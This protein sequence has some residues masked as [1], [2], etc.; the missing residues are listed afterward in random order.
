MGQTAPHY[1]TFGIVPKDVL[2][3]VL[4]AA[5]LLAVSQQNFLL[6]HTLAEFFAIVIAI[7]MLVV[8]WYM[9]PFTR[10]SFLLFLGCGYFWVG[11]LDLA[12]T[13]HYG[14][15]GVLSDAGGNS[16]TQY[17]ILTRYLES[18]ILLSAP[19]FLT[20]HFSHKLA[21]GLFGL[22]VAA[23]ITLQALGQLPDTYL[24]GSGLTP[25]KIYSEYAITAVL[26]LA[27]VNLR[28][29][30]HLLDSRMLNTMI[31]SIGLTIGAE[32]AFTFYVGIYD[33]SNIIG[34]LFKLASFWLIF[35][36][37][38]R[39]TL[40]EPFMA[41]SRSSS[42]YDAV[43][44]ATLVTD[45]EGVIRQANRSAA[46]MA[47]MSHVSLVGMDSHALFHPGYRDKEHCPVCQANREGRN[48][49]GLEIHDREQRR[50]YDVSLARIDSEASHQGMVQVIHDISQRKQA[51]ADFRTLSGLKDSIVENLPL[52]LFAKDAS[53]H[54]YV[55]WNKAAEQLTGLSK[56]E[57]LGH[58]DYDFWPKQEAEFFIRK[59]R[60][61]LDSGRLHDI[62]EETIS[63]RNG[64]RLLHTQ[65]IP[66]YS[67]DGTPSYLLGISQDI[68][69]QKEIE[70]ALQQSQ[71]LDA[72]G[73]LSGGIAH[74]YNNMLGIIQG[75]SE[76]LALH[77][78]GDEKLSQY[79]QAI[80]H[81][82]DRGASLSRQLLA[83]S[84]TN[85]NEESAVDLNTFITDERHI[86]E[87]TLTASI[88]LALEMQPHLW[89]V[90][91]NGGDLEDSLI[92]LV[93]N[94]MHAIDGSGTITI[95]TSNTILD[96]TDSNR[97]NLPA[98]DYVT[99]SVQDDGCGMSAETLKR[100]FE[101]FYS[102]KGESGTGLG[103]SQVYGFVKRSHGAIDVQS[104][105]GRGTLFSLHL[106]RHHGA[107]GRKTAPHG[108][109]ETAKLRGSETVLVVDD[110][111]SLGQLTCEILRDAGYHPLY[112]KDANAA[113]GLLD[114]QPVDLLLS[115]VIMPGTNGYQLADDVKRRHPQVK[116]QM[117]SGYGDREELQ[118]G[119][120]RLLANMLY[121]P[122]SNNEL[123][124]RIRELLDERDGTD[125]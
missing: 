28:A 38:V 61:V 54:R 82:T 20:R 62:P 112:A 75:Y 119:D 104:D 6:F 72:M 1:N 21:M 34:H 97:L 68:T 83:F 111:A 31:L 84:R 120:A 39:S 74:D 71:K 49:H 56:E 26:L 108:T 14:G 55:E 25:F 30:R 60:E 77:L 101:P 2:A 80:R 65:K 16:S 106:P 43:P 64:Q 40:E 53:E 123:L 50:W 51:E 63:T 92:N 115:D 125:R 22:L 67:D 4:M 90:W 44:D 107:A 86:L 66:I 110:E 10:N 98:G 52:M 47:G 29:H 15:M 99:L 24:T 59:D 79:I 105:E 46:A 103:L 48:I 85:A 17:W 36:T 100:I 118:P 8:S 91:L 93:I 121:K 9:Y 102:T 37:M 3:L 113:L 78:K 41:L 57:I 109:P 19:L 27:M 89:P 124:Q 73:K 45:N 11:V 94:A 23:I 58:S 33:L 88:R 117:I 69:H 122:F 81:A 18:L 35:I 7:L 87:K 95:R 96:S 114:A 116:I 12:H 13:L 5:V 32:L 70:Q 42:S 76:L